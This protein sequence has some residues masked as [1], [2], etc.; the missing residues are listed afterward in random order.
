[1][2][3]NEGL[4]AQTRSGFNQIKSL[5][6]FRYAARSPV[7]SDFSLTFLHIRCEKPLSYLFLPSHPDLGWED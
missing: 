1:M 2:L 7:T 4:T 6:N 3:D 5:C